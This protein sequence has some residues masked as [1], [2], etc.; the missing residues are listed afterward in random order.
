MKT[1]VTAEGVSA[2][3]QPSSALAHIAA[4]AAIWFDDGGE[5]GVQLSHFKVGIEIGPQRS[6]PAFEGELK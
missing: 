6:V 5:A 4:D 3:F 2:R 1:P